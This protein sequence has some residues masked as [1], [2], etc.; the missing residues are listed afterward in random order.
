MIWWNPGQRSLVLLL[1]FLLVV[2]LSSCVVYPDVMPPIEDS[3]LITP[4]AVTYEVEPHEDDIKTVT[5]KVGEMRKALVTAVRYEDA[6]ASQNK[7][8]EQTAVLFDDRLE[9]NDRIVDAHYVG[10]LNTILGTTV[11]VGIGSLITAI[12]FLSMR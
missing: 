6:V 7:A 3:T 12:I 9:A 10:V 8:V 1:S 5:V 11:G 4:I 2:V